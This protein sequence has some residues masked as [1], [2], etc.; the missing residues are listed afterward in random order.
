[1][2]ELILKKNEFPTPYYIRSHIEYMLMNKTIQQD[3][4]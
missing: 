1:M 4:I 3:I 2:I